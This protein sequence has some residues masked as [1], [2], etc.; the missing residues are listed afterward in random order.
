MGSL[1][2]VEA[3]PGLDI[4]CTISVTCVE[5]LI[6]FVPPLVALIFRV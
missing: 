6:G 2:V 4:Y 1:T 3:A 5:L